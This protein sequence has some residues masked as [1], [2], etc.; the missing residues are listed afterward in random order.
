[1][2]CTGVEMNR[3]WMLDAGYWMVGAGSLLKDRC[4]LRVA[5]RG[6]RVGDCR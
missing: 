5:G 3:Y 2:D 1:M 6:L 4:A